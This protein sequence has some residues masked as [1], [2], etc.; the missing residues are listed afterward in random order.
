MSKWLSFNIQPRQDGK[1]TDIYQVSNRL[2]GVIVGEIKW[3]GGFRK[4]VFAPTNDFIFDA[5]CMTDIGQFLEALMLERK[6][7]KQRV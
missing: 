1:K 5:S 6:L 3:Y 7:I 2:T 4:Y